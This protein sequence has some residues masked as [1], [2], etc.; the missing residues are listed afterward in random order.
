MEKRKS[1]AYLNLNQIVAHVPVGTD[2]EQRH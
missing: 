2:D 1:W